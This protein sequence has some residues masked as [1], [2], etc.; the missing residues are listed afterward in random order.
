MKQIFIILTIVASSLC[1]FAFGLNN[2]EPSKSEVKEEMT[3]V[4]TLT[5]EDGTV[6]TKVMTYDEIINFDESELAPLAYCSYVTS[7]GL[8]P[9]S[10]ATCNEAF[11]QHRDCLCNMGYSGWCGLI[12][13]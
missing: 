5:F 2:T 10:A 12:R 3:W 4:I 7:G 13:E 11:N 1:L 6:E 9:T 8:C